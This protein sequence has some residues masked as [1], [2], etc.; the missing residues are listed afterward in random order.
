MVRSRKKIALIISLG[1][2]FSK[3]GGL[4]RQLVIASV[5]GVGAAYDAFNYAYVIPGFFLVLVGGLN[6]P[7]HN[8]IVSVL[9]R[10]KK[11]QAAF[12]ISSVITSISIFLFFLSIIIF[13][14]ADQII[15]ILG[16]GLQIEI[17]QIA[18]NQLKIMAP[19]T[20][21]S[22]LIG[23]GF[24]ALNA[25]DHFF[26][27][28]ISPIISNIILISWIGFLVLDQSQEI[29]LT[30]INNGLEITLA[31][32]TF[33][34]ALTQWIFQIPLLIKRGLLKIRNVWNWGNDSIKEFWGI[35]FPAVI[36]SG[37]LQINVFTDLF[38]ASNIAGAASGLGYANF[39][40][41]APLGL[42]SNAI[43]LPLMPSFAKLSS[44]DNWPFLYKEIQKGLIISIISMVALGSIFVSL[45]T[46]IVQ[47]AF[48]RGAFDI[49]A[50][51]FVGEI[52]IAYGIGM[53]AYLCRDLFVRIFYALGESK[54]PLKVSTIGIVIN[55]IFDWIFIGGPSPW[56]PQF[57]FNFG[58]PGLV[59]A[60]GIVNLISCICLIISL[61]NKLKNLPLRKWSQ[62]IVK[63]FLCG[64]ISGLTTWFVN[65]NFV[66]SQEIYWLLLKLIIAMSL[67]ITSF[68]GLGILLNINELKVILQ[69][70]RSKIN[71]R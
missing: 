10:K 7:L 43:I 57:T 9:S 19:I 49:Y 56:G 20:L 1:T 8:A 36:S 30:N 51:N 50:I 65:I 67:G 4:I 23:V 63:I 69:I 15:T 16:P 62:D 12:I 33:L 42:I 11:A 60:T 35:A 28:S 40:A 26:L 37:M 32:A 39:I 55:I 24:G 54:T 52:L 21:I 22:G 38:F 44:K 18:V 58:A 68:F 6:G 46:L 14:T 17:H 31:Q 3:V 27:P 48:G 2:L 13:F 5:F 29:L 71:L 59:L 61:N 64:L 25:Y 53:P 47:I 70:S 66:F 45:G 41:Q 34:G